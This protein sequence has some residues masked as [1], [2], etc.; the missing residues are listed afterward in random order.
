MGKARDYIP[1][2]KYG[3][4]IYPEDIAGM[5]GLPHVGNI[6]Y[7]DPNSGNDTSNSGTSQDDALKT[8]ATAYGKATSGN[9]D[10]IIIAPSGGT[11]RTSETTAITW[12]KRFTHLIGSAAPTLQDVRAGIS[13]GTGG[14]LT[15]SENGC[16]FKN[17][18][19]TSSV[20]TDVTVSLTGDY[21]YF[22][23]VDFKGTYNATSIGSTPWRALSMTGAE[24]NTFVG[25]TIG[26]DT[27][28]RSAANASLEFSTACARNV[29]DGCFFPVFTDDATA[30]FV[31]A[32]SAAD[33]DR[34]TIF[35]SCIFHNAVN[36]SS[37][38]MTV[39]MSIHAAVGGTFILE[40]CT[41]IGASDLSNNFA[42]IRANPASASGY[43]ANAAGTQ[44]L[45]GLAIT[46][47]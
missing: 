12:A 26:S 10:V 44:A 5:L 47:A 22:E 28:T 30:L 6:Y 13:F 33:M 37:S 7:V 9:H 1:A 11:G 8:V 4:R 32:D 29:F 2:L 25:C 14:S 38:T 34:F 41:M 15:I 35:R 24:E 39:G 23:G 16:I 46:P 27:M 18:T 40:D 21:N 19:L 17:L 42:N 43:A 36:S 20:D 45:A 31:I 3:H